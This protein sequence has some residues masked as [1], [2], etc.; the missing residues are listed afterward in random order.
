MPG[1]EIWSN[2]MAVSQAS[3]PLAWAASRMIPFNI[4]IRVVMVPVGL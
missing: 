4:V 2:A 1:S 3:A